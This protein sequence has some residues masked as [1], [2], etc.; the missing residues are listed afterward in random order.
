MFTFDETTT[1]C[2]C[3]LCCLV[4]RQIKSSSFI[5]DI[6]SHYCDDDGSVFDSSFY[7]RYGL[8]IKTTHCQYVCVLCV[9]TS[10]SALKYWEMKWA[11]KP[12]PLTIRAKDFRNVIEKGNRIK[13]VLLFRDFHRAHFEVGECAGVTG[14]ISYR[15]DEAS[16]NLRSRELN[17]VQ[18][19]QISKRKFANGKFPI[20]QRQ[21]KKTKL[22]CVY[23]WLQWR[24]MKIIKCAHSSLAKLI[25]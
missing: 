13:L 1:V 21:S 23:D 12:S 19:K 16:H 2:V 10:S 6:R 14:A 11:N 9:C 4:Y 17:D 7:A 25:I 8:K 5:W 20:R 18:M 24:M 3:A 22:L 15:H